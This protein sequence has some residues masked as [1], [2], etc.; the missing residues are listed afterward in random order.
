MQQKIDRVHAE[1]PTEKMLAVPNRL[2]KVNDWSP[3][4][5]TLQLPNVAPSSI[6]LWLSL[7]VVLNRG[8]L[9]EGGVYKYPWGR[10][11]LR[12]LQNGNF[13]H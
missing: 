7:A 10:Q 4:C 2:K 9:P 1:D 5:D 13:D 8:E 11:L 12:A 6:R 3:N